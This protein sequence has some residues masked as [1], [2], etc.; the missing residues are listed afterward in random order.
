MDQPVSHKAAKKGL[1]KC[2]QLTWKLQNK[3][4]ISFQVCCG[5]VKRPWSQN[6]LFCLFVF[7]RISWHCTMPYSMPLAFFF[8]RETSLFTT[9]QTWRCQRVVTEE[10]HPLFPATLGMHSVT[11]E[12]HLEIQYK[13]STVLSLGLPGAL[14]WMLLDWETLCHSALYNTMLSRPAESSFYHLNFLQHF[15]IKKGRRFVGLGNV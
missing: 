5:S 12:W 8:G 13:G 4:F 7:M 1:L 10:V 15:I 3:G 2:V 14:A 11:S 6:I 9:K